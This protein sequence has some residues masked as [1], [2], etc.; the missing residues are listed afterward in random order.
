MREDRP[1]VPTA[2]EVCGRPPGP[3][4][5]GVLLTWVRGVEDGR[6]VWTCPECSRRHARS[7]EGRLDSAWW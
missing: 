3:D 7:I 5:A 2:C 4:E 6:A 1:A